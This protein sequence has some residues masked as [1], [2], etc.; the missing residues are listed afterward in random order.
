MDALSGT[1]RIA[2]LTALLLTLASALV[3]SGSAMLIPRTEQAVATTVGTIPL[4]IEGDRRFAA[5]DYD[6][7]LQAYD[8]A[9]LRDPEDVGLYY[10]AGAA[11]SH[12]NEREQAVAMFLWAVRHGTP[13]REEVR[14]A[15]K[16]LE[17][18]GELAATTR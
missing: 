8:E 2:W 16:W 1:R 11:L 4:M 15:R 7:A 14:L 5:G 18:A 13:D 12:L 9:L 6:G 17:A 10:R 3:M